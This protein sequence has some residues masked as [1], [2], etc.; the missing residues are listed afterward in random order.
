MA[1]IP[2]TPEEKRQMLAAI[3]VAGVEDLFR[4]IPDEARLHRPMNLPPA[5]SEWELTEYFKFLARK[6]SDMESRPAFLGA[7][8]YRH[9]V[10]SVV[11]A[12]TGR[13]EF[14][15]SYTPYQA[16]ASQ[17][18]L[19]AIYEFQSLICRLTGMDVAN[20]SM[21]DGA[22]ALA[23]AALMAYH[24]TGR[25]TI[26]VSRGVH[27]EWRAVLRTYVTAGL[28]LA[29]E[30][31]PL[32]DGQTDLHALAPDRL[33]AAA[34]VILQQ[35][36]F[37]GA[38]EPMP[39]VR[40]RLHGTGAQFVAAVAEPVSL[41]VLTRP[42]D[43]GADIVAGEGQGIGLEP[44]FGG[45][46]AGFLSATKDH[47]R[48]LPGRIVG[49][50]KDAQ[51]REGFVLTL[52][53]REQHIRREKASSNICTNEGVCA[54]AVAVWLSALGARGFRAL[55]ELNVQKA[56]Y[57]LDRI[58]AI[59]GFRRAIAAPFFNEFPILGPVP[60]HQIQAALAAKGILGGYRLAGDYPELGDALLLCVT[61]TVSKQAIDALASALAEIA[62]RPMQ[63]V[64]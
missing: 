54:L 60:S 21:Y 61:E 15:T 38:V 24:A 18:T 35:P 40:D 59:P 25:R 63:A 48:R 39:A 5:L 20:A 27:P 43:Y 33:G 26:L 3:G 14:L 42:G 36:N 17:G 50:A 12:I 1:Y 37:L 30:E 10:P 31:I 19:Q 57:A 7:G 56:H 9:F 2:H 6:N 49:R 51:G 46:Y 13:G 29:V 62:R 16:E 53:A 28:N 45:P 58:T 52:Q 11:P 64:R 41:G 44:S 32:K 8:A 23:E 22:S 4:D 55:S 34:A 47:L